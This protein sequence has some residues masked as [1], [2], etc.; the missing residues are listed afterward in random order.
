MSLWGDCGGIVCPRQ[1]PHA[2][3]ATR[4]PTVHPAILLGLIARET[5]RQAG[6]AI[7]IPESPLIARSAL[8]GHHR[9]ASRG[10]LKTLPVCSGD[11]LARW[12]PSRPYIPYR[13]PA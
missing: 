10:M 6:I 7:V 2:H 12:I 11:A 13:G 1:T 3:A 8:G 4:T 5:C 9:A